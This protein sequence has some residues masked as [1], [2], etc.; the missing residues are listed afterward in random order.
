MRKLL[1]ILLLISTPAWAGPNPI[2]PDPFITPGDVNAAA[3]VEM[4]C[5]TGYSATV[6]NVTQSTK[7]KVFDLYDLNRVPGLYEVDH[8]VSLQLGGTN[9]IANLWPQHYFIQPWNAKVKDALE[10]HLR[11]QVCDGKM[12]LQE[13]QKAIA[14][15]WI[16]AYCKY[17]NKKPSSCYD[18][19]KGVK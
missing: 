14:E 13:A 10:N 9:N 18:Y 11:R 17:Y 7:D 4:I 12:T 16:K 15:D 5:T 3:T 8:L 1:S 6:R 2:K 19:M